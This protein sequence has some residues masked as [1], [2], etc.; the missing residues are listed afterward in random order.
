MLPAKKQL[1]INELPDVLSVREVANLLRVTTSTIK[2]WIHKGILPA[3]RISSR[4][5]QQVLKKDV[6]NLLHTKHD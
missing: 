5:D 3:H 4:G 2:R 1:K 6:L